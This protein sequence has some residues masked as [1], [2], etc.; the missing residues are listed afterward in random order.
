MIN[1]IVQYVELTYRLA[2]ALCGGTF[3]DQDF[4]QFIKKRFPGGVKAWNKTEPVTVSKFLNTEW[5]HGIKPD[6]D[7]TDRTW[8]LDLPKRCKRGQL[9]VTA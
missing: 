8:T 6:F 9:D 5:E 3:L 4:E 1:S 2:G 7:G